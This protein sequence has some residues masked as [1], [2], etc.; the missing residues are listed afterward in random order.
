[1]N[2]AQFHDALLR[3]DPDFAAAVQARLATVRPLLDYIESTIG[4]ST[5]HL[6]HARLLVLAD[7]A[8]TGLGLPT[9]SSG[10]R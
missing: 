10:Y 5:A 6:N 7:R 3:A 4:A 1:M 8:A 9:P 2:D